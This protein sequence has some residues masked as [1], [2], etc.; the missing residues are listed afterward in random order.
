MFGKLLIVTGVTCKV[1][2]V[3]IIINM[4]SVYVRIGIVRSGFPVDV[5]CVPASRRHLLL[6]ASMVAKD[7]DNY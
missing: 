2:E 3:E 1:R 7:A 4:P 5:G 6:L